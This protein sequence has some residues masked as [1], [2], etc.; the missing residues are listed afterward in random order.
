MSAPPIDRFV[1]SAF[2][3]CCCVGLAHLS[4]VRELQWSECGLQVGGVG[5]EIVES[6]SD[7]G[8]ELR[9]VRARWAR[10]RDLVEGAHDCGCRE[11]ESFKI[12]RKC[13]WNFD[14]AWG[15]CAR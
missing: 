13:G 1:R 7:A 4:R 11:M 14:V 3:L 9:W 8:L 5:L 10:G 12:S 15:V 6:A 2:H